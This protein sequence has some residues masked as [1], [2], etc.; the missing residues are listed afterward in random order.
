MQGA[1]AVRT[2]GCVVVIVVMS[3][4]FVSAGQ[5]RVGDAPARA[6][7]GDGAL[8][9]VTF[10]YTGAEQTYTVP[11]GVTSLQVQAVGASGG[12]SAGGFQPV[13]GGTGGLV[14]GE[15]GAGSVIKPGDT[16]YVEVGGAGGNAGSGLAEGGFNGGGAGGGGGGGGA[17][18][19]RT[20]SR[21]STSCPDGVPS[22]L[23]RLIVAAGGGGAGGCPN[24]FQPDLNA[25]G[26][27]A[28]QPGGTPPLAGLPVGGGAGTLVGPGGAGSD[29]G[30][31][32][33]TPEPGDTPGSIDGT[34]GQGDRFFPEH[35]PGCGSGGGGG[36]GYFGGGGGGW[37]YD[38]AGDVASGGG[39]GGANFASPLAVSGVA[40]GLGNGAPRVLITPQ[41]ASA[42][43]ITRIYYN[44]PGPDT[45]S[46]HSLNA[47]WIRLTNTGR[48]VQQLRGWSITD[49]EGHLYRFQRL[50]LR[51][52]ASVTVHS[53]YGRDTAR[54]RYWSR[55]GYNWD[56]TRDLARLHSPHGTLADQCRYDNSNAS[57]LRC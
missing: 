2:F 1:A 43:Q 47:E 38:A 36:G 7:V 8:A 51:P 49:A 10:T 13:Q 46:N 45:G 9:P 23:T 33:A 30:P 57:Q 26:G 6:G 39:G 3:V 18:D 12:G 56:N 52:G 14:V 25:S 53:G 4:M 17:S 31:G 20:C 48:T 37:V 34:G 16:L 50:A 44:S 15:L 32:L 5:A 24:E 41:P 29:P 19:V 54:D 27:A 35:L 42:I 21:T 11:A 40:F 28:G 22:A 55:R